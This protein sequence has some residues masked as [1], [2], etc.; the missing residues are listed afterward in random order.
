MT[1]A[2]HQ[3]TFLQLR[4]MSLLIETYCDADDSKA[5]FLLL[6]STRSTVSTAFSSDQ[7]WCSKGQ[8]GLKYFEL[9]R[10]LFAGAMKVQRAKTSG[11]HCEISKMDMLLQ[12]LTSVLK[13]WTCFWRNYSLI[14]FNLGLEGLDLWACLKSTD[15]PYQTISELTSLQTM[16]S[17]FGQ[18]DRVR[19]LCSTDK[20]KTFL[21][22][23]ADEY[24]SLSKSLIS[25]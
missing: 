2:R 21:V 20:Q 8:R 11:Q 19:S 14:S 24:A 3:C 9:S 16:F 1:F 12:T 5:V 18:V 22:D 23:I 6:Y 15:I 10:L 4:I 13:I 7:S 17:R 25:P